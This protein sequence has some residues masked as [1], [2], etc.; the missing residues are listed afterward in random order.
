MH[1]CFHEKRHA[2]IASLF[3][4]L[5]LFITEFKQTSIK[6]AKFSKIYSFAMIRLLITGASGFIGSHTCSLLLEMGY[7]I[8]AM[9]SY[10]NSSP[11]T[12]KKII[13]ILNSKRKN[14]TNKLKIV[15]LYVIYHE[16]PN[17]LYKNLKIFYFLP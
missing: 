17:T 2:C 15:F 8:I 16:T 5:T 10:I 13:E 4:I 11:K 3:C 14:I 6:V 7:E 12:Y 9:D 1:E